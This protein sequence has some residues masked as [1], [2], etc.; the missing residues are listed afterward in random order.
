MVKLKIRRADKSEVGIIADFQQ[1]MAWETEKLELRE[2]VL[3]AGV[4]AVF[5][6]SNKGL[7]FVAEQDGNV[8][9]S[10]MI[11]YEWSD[12]RNGTVWWI[13]SVYVLPTF[14]GQGVF[15]QMYLHLKEHVM[16]S[17]LRGLRL[18]VDKTNTA[19]QKVY[20]SIGMT[21]EHY[22]MYEWMKG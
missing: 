12:W 8:V 14:R 18:Y 11:T 9:A 5:E 15:K 10:L 6:D 1:K 4:K 22:A 20:D 21:Q 19:A 16:Q 13:Q 2:D 17:E 3:T 7:Y